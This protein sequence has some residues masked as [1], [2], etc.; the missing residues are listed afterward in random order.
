M[1]LI[2]FLNSD[3]LEL[4]RS[5]ENY[6]GS[7]DQFLAHTVDNFLDTFAQ[8]SSSDLLSTWVRY[9][10]VNATALCDAIKN[11]IDQYF[12]GHPSHAYKILAD[13]LKVIDR[14]IK[15]LFSVDIAGFTTH[16]YRIR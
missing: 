10:F 15:T 14:H 7:F 5:W 11:S 4:P 2:E 3:K 6:S 1:D 8:I 9:E 16:L 12:L 13:A